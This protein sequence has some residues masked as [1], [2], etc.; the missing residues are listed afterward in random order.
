MQKV[1]FLAILTL[2]T[3]IIHVIHLWTAKRFSSSQNCQIIKYI[4]VL[5]KKTPNTSE[6][7]SNIPN[8]KWDKKLNFENPC[9]KQCQF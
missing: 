3:S 2:H 6:S 8:L 7:S 9:F 5:I 1:W 4:F